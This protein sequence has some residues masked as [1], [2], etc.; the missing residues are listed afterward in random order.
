MR[1]AQNW[2]CDSQ[3]VVQKKEKRFRAFQVTLTGME[4]SLPV[5]RNEKSYWG[6]FF[7]SG[8]GNLKKSEFDHSNFFKGWKQ[9]Y[10]NTER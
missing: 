2:L 4:N 8:G 9:Q 6:W 7:L 10:V 3:I 1:I 5:G